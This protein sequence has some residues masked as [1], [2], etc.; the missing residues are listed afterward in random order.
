LSQD[1]LNPIEVALESAY[2]ALAN[3]E[4][5]FLERGLHEIPDC[6]L[7]KIRLREAA[8]YL[9]S[10]LAEDAGLEEE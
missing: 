4:Q 7:A 1:T 10:Q 5:A 3:I 6:G 2:V 8:F 9:D